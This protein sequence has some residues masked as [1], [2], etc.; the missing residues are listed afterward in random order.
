MQQMLTGYF[1]KSGSPVL[2]IL[3]SGPV[4]K[5][6]E[7]EAIVDTGFTGFL[8]MPLVQAISVGLVLHG[9]TTISIADGSTSYRLT[10]KGMVTVGEESEVGVVILEPASSLLLLG[11]AFLRQFKR[12]LFVSSRGVLLASE[13][14]IQEAIK[15][16]AA[17]AP[18]TIA[19]EPTS[20]PP[21]SQP[22]P[23]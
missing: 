20:G 14:A 15:R 5:G 6:R 12:T 10:A 21:Q 1:A 7:F 17:E 22:L 2:K 13:D 19:S 16:S 4:T 23:R 18:Q 3:V 11:M 9:T 8:S